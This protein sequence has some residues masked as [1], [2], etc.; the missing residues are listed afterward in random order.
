[1][2]PRKPNDRVAWIERSTATGCD[3]GATHDSSASEGRMRLNVGL[4]FALASEWR[5]R[6][7]EAAMRA[8]LLTLRRIT[9]HLSK[10]THAWQLNVGS[11]ANAC[12]GFWHPDADGAWPCLRHENALRSSGRKTVDH[13][14]VRPLAWGDWPTFYSP[15]A[16]DP[17]VVG[18]DPPSPPRMGQPCG[19]SAGLCGRPGALP[20]R[21]L[22]AT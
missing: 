6:D 1:M 7:V 21:S 10:R 11:Q 5:S 19:R 20:S 12:E 9:V 14:C 3:C 17:A 22:W 8:S 13:A 4:R 2:P 16:E 15:W 18:I